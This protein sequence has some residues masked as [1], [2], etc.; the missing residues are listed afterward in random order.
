MNNKVLIAIVFLL[1]VA[2]QLFVPAKMISNREDVLKNGKE[3]KFITAPIDPTDPFRG[4]YISL[5]FDETQFLLKDKT[6]WE[7]GEKIYVYLKTDS[8]G[9]AKIDNI[10][11]DKP[12]SNIDFIEAKVSYVN[13]DSKGNTI[14]IEYPFDR[15]YMEESKA[16]NAETVYGKYQNDST[17]PAYAKVYIKDGDAVL[18]DVIVKGKS[19]K[20]Y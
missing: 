1:M 4:G 15:F 11:K 7:T 3:F 12:V 13:N 5:F 19:I 2:A 20:D 17:Y 18:K 16:E 10:S 14:S 6:K 9:Y 8:L